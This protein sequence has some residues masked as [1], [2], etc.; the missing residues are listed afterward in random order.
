MKSHYIHIIFALI[1]RSA[2]EIPENQIALT[3][4]QRRLCGYALNQQ[5]SVS[6]FVPPAEN[7]HLFGLTLVTD[8]LSKSTRQTAPFEGPKLTEAFLG[9]FDKQV[10]T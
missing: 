1:S 9:R 5:T 3:S 8:F 4:I 2:R 7:Y 6:T 10:S